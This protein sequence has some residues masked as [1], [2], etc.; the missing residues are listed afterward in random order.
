MLDLSH[1]LQ[2]KKRLFWMLQ[3]GGW[4]GFSVLQYVTGLF[5]G[6]GDGYA[7]VVLGYALTG[8]LLTLGL[9]Q[10]YL[11]LWSRRLWQIGL[12]IIISSFICGVAWQGLRIGIFLQVFGRCPSSGDCGNLLFTILKFSPGSFYLFLCWSG[13][14]F[15][16]KYY[17][18][19]EQQREMTL[20]A[21]GMAHEAQLKML[22]YQLNP[23]FLFNTLNAISTLVLEKNTASANRMVTRLSSFL[24]HSLDSD[25]MQKVTL[26]D[27]LS[28]MRLYLDI[29]Q[30]RF[31]ERL[32]VNM[33]VTE[34]A[35]R[36][37]VPS[38]VLQPL[39]ENAVK[40]AIA[41]RECGGV[42]G[43]TAK[44]FGN[45][46]LIELTDD[47]PGLPDGV[48]LTDSGRGVG[49]RNT[50]E[51]L[52]VLYNGNYSFTLKNRDT[53]GLAVSLRIPLVYEAE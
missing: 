21:T 14:Y 35:K 32:V 29:E 12:A 43:I 49:L 4:A 8:L 30:V 40:H 46:V 20:R 24:R 47:G 37:L 18:M 45:D 31:E 33:D 27:E 34:D 17:R 9:R 36:A 3:L 15:G 39:I 38:M 53:G 23:H 44:T 13:L 42:I 2:D 7:L 19:L 6:V 11:R 22:R 50:R 26:E 28:A 16:I 10:I 25:P 41:P 51:R 1:W 52:A 48:E 5:H